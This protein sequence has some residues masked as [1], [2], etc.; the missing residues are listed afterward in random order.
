MF[1]LKFHCLIYVNDSSSNQHFVVLGAEFSPRIERQV[2]PTAIGPLIIPSGGTMMFNCSSRG[3]TGHVSWFRPKDN[4]QV[5]YNTQVI[6][7]MQDRLRVLHNPQTGDYNLMLRYAQFPQDNG[8]WWCDVFGG[9]RIAYN[10]IV[11]VPPATRVPQINPISGIIFQVTSEAWTFSCVAHH[12]YPPV[13]L[14]WVRKSGPSTEFGA[15]PP[16]MTVA[17]DGTIATSIRLILSP[18]NHG[19]EFS[20]LADHPTFMG[21]TFS[22]DLQFVIADSKAASSGTDKKKLSYI[23]VKSV[24]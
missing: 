22:S 15:L 16:S 1:H 10:L 5:S 17:P 7:D 12:A 6:S 8:T 14:R 18:F 20:C 9:P 3:R 2:V 24:E 4:L 23:S 19:S 21:K 11:M 13:V